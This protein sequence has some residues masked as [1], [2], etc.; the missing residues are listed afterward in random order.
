MT[1]AATPRDRLL[2]SYPPEV[3]DLALR[4]RTLI[5]ESLRVLPRVE[6]TVDAPARII[7][8]G[9]GPGYRGLVCTVILSRAEVKL[10]FN[11]GAE[12][13]DPGAILEGTGKVHRYVRLRTVVDLKKPGLKRLFKAAQ[14]AWAQRNAARA[15]R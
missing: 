3:Q 14:T 6:E 15:T 10:G 9:C 11:R 7:G 4:T 5:L 12:L 13:P 8:Y 1:T 2:A